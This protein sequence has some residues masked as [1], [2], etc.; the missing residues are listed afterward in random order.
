MRAERYQPEDS[1]ERDQPAQ[2][3]L[4]AV[5]EMACETTLRDGGHVPTVIAEGTRMTLLG[6]FPELPPT[7]QERVAMME[8]A[9]EMLGD[10]E[11]VGFLRRVY[12]ISEAWMSRL[13][14]PV[15]GGVPPSQDPERVEVLCVAG[16][17]VLE[18]RS[19]LKLYEMVRDEYGGLSELLPVGREGDGEEQVDSPLLMAFAAGYLGGVWRHAH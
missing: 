4:E 10:R 7:H 19:A 3:S 11:A 6:N 12:F 5:A 16:L 9:G 18:R 8:L 14:R 13:A 1:P 2:L 15:A 17:E